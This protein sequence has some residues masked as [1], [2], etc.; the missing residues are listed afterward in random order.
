MVTTR[1]P[2][3]VGSFFER[4]GCI[5]E[6][7]A[8]DRAAAVDASL[9]ALHKAA[10]F[11]CVRIITLAEG[12]ISELHVGLKGTKG[13]LYLKDLANKTRRGLEGR[14]REGRSGGGLC[15]G[16]RVVRGPV[17]RY[18]EAERGLREIDLAQA[19]VI[20]RIFRDYGAGFSLKRIALALNQEAIAGP[21]G[22]AWT[23][24]AGNSNRGKGSGILNN[25]LYIGT[26][27]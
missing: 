5:W 16:Y 13:A 12:E 24:S 18:G 15:Y 1:A 4:R 3:L 11:A 27:T 10:N 8:L 7:E 23:T 26:L 14:V 2:R 6:G 20:R 21:R 9:A 25:A 22:G 19:S 17:D